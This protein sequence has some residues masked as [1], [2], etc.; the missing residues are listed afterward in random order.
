MTKQQGA[1]WRY[2]GKVALVVGA[3]SGIGLAIAER[4]IASGAKVGLA[5]RRADELEALCKRLGER[6]IALPTDTGD[7]DQVA[8]MVDRVAQTF[9]QLDVAF[10]VAGVLRLGSIIDLSAED[11]DTVQDSVLRGTFFC[12]KHQAAQM[13]CQG[14][15]GAIVNITSVSAQIPAHGACAYS[16]AKAGLESLTRTAAL[17]L[18]DHDIRV[19]ALSPGLV[20]TPLTEKT[21][22]RGPIIEA[23]NRRIAMGRPA[24]TLE[25]TGPA[26]F[27]GSDEASYITGSSLVADGGWSITG[28]P[29]LRALR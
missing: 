14:T 15:G 4:L 10:N 8:Q 7:N 27:L 3:S 2:D 16:A 20:T 1:D 22:S 17:E 23:Y 13:I 19:N 5:A 12:L 18:A 11:W 6:A 29:D 25:M 26:L 9:G 28:Y 21:L 24:E